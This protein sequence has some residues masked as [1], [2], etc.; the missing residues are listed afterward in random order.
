MI[1]AAFSIYLDLIRF[2]ASMGVF[3]CHLG[4]RRISGGIGWQ[5]NAYG[6]IAV[7]IFFVLSG[8]VI[9]YVASTR[10]K[11]FSSYLISRISRLYSVV[12]IALLL[13]YAF[14]AAGF[15]YDPKFYT[16]MLG[17]GKTVSYLSSLFFINEYKIFNFGGIAPGTNVP[18]WSLSFE[19]TYYVVAAF[20]LFY[21]PLKA[22]AASACLL[23]LAGPTILALLPAWYLGYFCYRYR[24]LFFRLPKIAVTLIAAVSTLM[25]IIGIPIILDFL[26]DDNFGFSLAWGLQQDTRRLADDYLVVTAFCL[27]LL[28]MQVLLENVSIGKNI[29]KIIRWLGLL[30]FPLY[31]IHMPALYFFRVITPF[32]PNTLPNL[33]FL[34]AM[35]MLIVIAVTPVCEGLKRLLKNAL[36]R[37][38]IQLVTVRRR[39]RA[40][41]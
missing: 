31:L 33:G 3:V 41:E 40:G 32:T 14:D 39:A 34:V 8:Y 17:S 25:L 6:G 9:A 27:N 4:Y 35:V 13:T 30:T 2:L 12:L 36:T 38:S 10:E 37:A 21:R 11:T 1:S 18:F 23:F 19:A 29:E 20:M 15:A 28:S 5:L 16:D 26:P 24:T 22:V 7:I